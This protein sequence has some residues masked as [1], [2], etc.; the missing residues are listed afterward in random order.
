MPLKISYLLMRWLF[1][2]LV[3]VFR[4]DQAK[5]AEFLVLRHENAILRRNAD[6]VRYEP[7]DRAWFAALAPFIPRRQG[8]GIFPRDTRDTTGLP[9][10]T[11]RAEVRSD[12]PPL[13]GRPPTVRSIARVATRLARENPA[14]GLPANP[15]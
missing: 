5:D 3:L 6:R 15:R 14:V 8:P 13:D 10:Q 7:S 12:H 9:P 1:R 4:G 11:D 2:L